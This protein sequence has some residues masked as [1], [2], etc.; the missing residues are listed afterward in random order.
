METGKRNW[1]LGSIGL[2]FNNSLKKNKK[3]KKQTWSI[4]QEFEFETKKNK[5]VSVFQEFEFE[6]KIKQICLDFSGI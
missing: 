4:F 5:P 1:G 2:R 3:A 6:T